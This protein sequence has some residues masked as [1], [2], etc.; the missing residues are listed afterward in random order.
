[1]AL[2]LTDVT[3]T[4]VPAHSTDHPRLVELINAAF[5]VYP[6]MKEPRTSP[7]GI[8][9]ELC[10][11][12]MFVL[13]SDSNANVIGCAM[14]RPVSGVDWGVE[15]LPEPA[16]HASGAYLGLVAVDP[17]ARKG[18]VGKRLVAAAE[19]AARALG[20][21]AMLLGTLAEMGNVAYY[22]AMDYHTV[23]AYEFEAGHWGVSIPHN[24]HI[25]ERLL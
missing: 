14:V 18:G 25:M 19:D 15:P 16:N 11:G 5:F 20:Y 8:A 22:E 9:E 10:D 21:H 1:M 24:Y 6:F 3:L 12:A 4:T 17:A 2:D 7:E 23:A 13:A